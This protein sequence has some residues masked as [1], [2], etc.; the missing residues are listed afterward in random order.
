MQHSYDSLDR[1]GGFRRGHL[2]TPL[3]HRDFRVLWMGMTVSLIGDGIF[4]VAIAWETST[5]WTA[6]EASPESG[7]SCR[8]GRVTSACSGRR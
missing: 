4:L 1:P 3:R 6:P 5:L 2:L 7:S 8:F